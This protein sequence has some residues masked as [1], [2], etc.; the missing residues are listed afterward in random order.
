MYINLLFFS[1]SSCTP[2]PYHV[3]ALRTVILIRP[4]PCSCVLI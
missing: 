1:L 3:L 2:L 4:S